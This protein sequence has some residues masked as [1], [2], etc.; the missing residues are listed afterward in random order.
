MFEIKKGNIGLAQTK[1][2]R[3]RLEE[4]NDE[5]LISTTDDFLSEICSD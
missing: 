2:S 1:L 5:K 3:L 4:S